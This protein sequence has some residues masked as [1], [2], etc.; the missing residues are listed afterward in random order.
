[1][2]NRNGCTAKF[3]VEKLPDSF[4][5]TIKMNLEILQNTINK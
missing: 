5:S 1:M 2:Q 4:I 3:K